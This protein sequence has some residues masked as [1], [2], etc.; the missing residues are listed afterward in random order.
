MGYIFQATAAYN[1]GKLYLAVPTGTNTINDTV[2]VVDFSTQKV[3]WYQYQYVNQGPA[4]FLGLWWDFQN[5]D[6]Y[7]AG[8]DGF[9]QIENF[10]VEPTVVTTGT[11]TSTGTATT[12]G[13]VPWSF[14]T[15]EWDTP[16]DALVENVAVE[17]IGGPIEVVAV[18]DSTNTNTLGTLTSSSKAWTTLPLSATIN[19]S[20]CFQFSQVTAGVITTNLLPDRGLPSSLGCLPTPGEV[21]VLSD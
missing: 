18:Y 15:R 20:L 11:G 5:N 2:F 12:S 19:N 7:A 4:G 10:V 6:M 21:S 16:T 8:V 13:P 14:I 9:Y 17:Y 1:E 3:W